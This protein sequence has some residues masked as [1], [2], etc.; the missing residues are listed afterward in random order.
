MVPQMLRDV[1]VERVHP[2]G[3]LASFERGTY[4]KDSFSILTKGK[5]SVIIRT[6]V[7]LTG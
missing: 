3:G 1:D 5:P 2:S 4:L 6:L 7:L